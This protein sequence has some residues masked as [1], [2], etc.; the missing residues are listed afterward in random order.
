M[1]VDVLIAVDNLVPSQFSG[2]VEDFLESGLRSSSAGLEKKKKMEKYVSEKN[3][4]FFFL[5]KTQVSSFHS[6][7][8]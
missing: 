8:E 2:C 7:S 6:F 3:K 4:I 1:V 5:Q